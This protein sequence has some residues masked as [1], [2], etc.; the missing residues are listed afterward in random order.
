MPV[1]QPG[2]CGGARGVKTMVSVN[3]VMVDGTGMCGGCRV[4][5]GGQVKFAC[6]EG[7]DF[8]GHQVDFDD[9]MA[10]LTRFADQE[11]AALARWS[12]SCRMSAPPA[13]EP[14]ELPDPFE[15]VHGG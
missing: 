11:K 4:K 15:E 12:E 3:P 2:G 14:I 6:V 13:E 10:R 9:L 8:D 1:A 7:P 5:V